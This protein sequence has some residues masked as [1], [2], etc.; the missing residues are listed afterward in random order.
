MSTVF[1]SAVRKALPGA[2]LAVD[3]FHVSQLANKAVGD[4]RRRVTYEAYGRRGRAADPEYTIK[5]LLVRGGEKLSEAA[6]GRLLCTLSTLGDAGRQLQ[7]AW[8]AKEL[9]RD[10]L[11]LSP[12][13]T[14]RATCRSQVSAALVK[15]FDYCGTVGGTVAEVVTLA[16]TVSAWREEIATAVLTGFSNAAAEGVNRLIKLVYRVAFGFTNV[17][18]QQRRSRYVASRSTRPQWL[19]SATTVAPR[20]VVA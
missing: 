2:A 17:P 16:E 7:A 20:E 9:L 3:F 19:H 4:V 18:N 8:K 1:K 10:V 14:G 6:R 15:F 5:G 12:T 13:R 11:K